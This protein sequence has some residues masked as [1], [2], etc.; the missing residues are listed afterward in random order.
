MAPIRSAA[1][2]VLSQA[3]PVNAPGVNADVANEA[4]P[5]VGD[6]ARLAINFG[7]DNYYGVEIRFGENCNEHGAVCA[8]TRCPPDTFAGAPS[9]TAPI[10]CRPHLSGESPTGRC[11]QFK[12]DC[13]PR[14]GGVD[15][16]PLCIAFIDLPEQ[17]DGT[18]WQG[19][20]AAALGCL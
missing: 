12:E 7:D 5:F 11:C 13:S 17:D 14:V 19:G 10:L 8:T 18:L 15:D 4:F 20:I 16:I 6:W 1:A 9:I 2:A 3:F